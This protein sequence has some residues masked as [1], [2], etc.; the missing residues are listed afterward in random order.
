M[1][2]MADK[3]FDEPVAIAV[4]TGTSVHV[5]SARKA[6]EVL[7]NE[8]PGDSATA[9]HIAARKSCLAVLEGTR[10]AIV[11]RRAFAAAAEEA[12]I[13]REPLPMPKGPLGKP[14]HWRKRK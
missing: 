3:P 14:V 6:A 7:L 8:W 13:L 4:S 11:A 1:A 10:K 5:A 2:L 9:K 12:G